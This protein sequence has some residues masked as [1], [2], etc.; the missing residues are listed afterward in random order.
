M[1]TPRITWTDLPEPVRS[2]VETAMGSPVVEWRGQT[3]G[4]SPGT[5][6]RLL[7]ADGRKVFCKSVSASLNGGSHELVRRE[8]TANRLLPDGLPSPRLL[9]GAEL[10]VD[11]DPW[12]VLLFDDLEGRHP[13]TPWR[14][15]ELAAA[16]EAL[17]AVPRVAP[18]APPSLPGVEELFGP[19][20]THW[21]DVI[22]DPPATLDPWLA[23]RLDDLAVRGH[24]ARAA[25]AGESL[26]H[27]D[28]RAD[29]MILDA[30]GRVWLVDWP[31]A[32]RGAAWV[33]TAVF[34]ATAAIAGGWSSE[35]QTL[36]DE[37]SAALGCDPD[38]LTDVWAGFLGYYVWVSEKP[39]PANLPTIRAF[40][41]NCRDR[42]LE[43][44]KAR[45]RD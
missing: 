36:V 2:E 1:F 15:D 38:L 43:S 7:L 27:L 41:A 31:Y 6:D 16:L 11:D 17:A 25:L 39:A 9:H 40:Q 12:A 5:A 3:G 29:N 33:D 8:L 44:V 14:V 13:H 23:A 32:C 20:L 24:R 4:F 42:L 28:S 34:A 19:D 22:A 30:D 21:D 10:T 45:L 18:V 37:A 26:S 35:H